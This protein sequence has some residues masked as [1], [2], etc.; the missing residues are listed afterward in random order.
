[1]TLKR[2]IAENGQISVILTDAILLAKQGKFH[3]RI[4]SADQLIQAIQRIRKHSA[5]PVPLQTESVSE[6][7]KLSELTIYHSRGN[8]I[9]IISVPLLDSESYTLFR[10]IPLPI[11]QQSNSRGASFAYIKP[12]SPF[13]AISNDTESYYRLDDNELN[14]CK[15]SGNLFICENMNVLYQTDSRSVCEVKMIIEPRFQDFASCDIRVITTARTHWSRI[16]STNQWVFSSAK[17]ETIKIKCRNRPPRTAIIN[18]T[19][20]LH[21]PPH[22]EVRTS[23]VVFTSFNKISRMIST[24]FAPREPLNIYALFS[25]AI[26]DTDTLNLSDLLFK[27]GSPTPLNRDSNASDGDVEFKTIINLAKTLLRQKNVSKRMYRFERILGCFS[28]LIGLSI[29]VSIAW[30]FILFS[31]ASYLC[32]SRL[33][34]KRN[35]ERKDK[36]SCCSDDQQATEIVELTES[37]LLPAN[38]LNASTDL[39]TL[40]VDAEMC[41]TSADNTYEQSRGH[42]SSSNITTNAIERWQ[43][44]VREQMSLKKNSTLASFRPRGIVKLSYLATTINSQYTWTSI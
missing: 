28:V 4:L 9:Y 5:F 11:Y 43:A 17:P 32:S 7:L 14:D 25:T 22:C 27:V 24:E 1:M 35:G 34:K 37:P 40:D 18:G 38:A 36:G 3:P 39:I 16:H 12:N 20:I 13:T 41:P 21:L 2:C 29:F 44:V 10:N 42:G 15:N 23:S 31:Q 30:K 33:C 6:L 26:D 19:G 8:L